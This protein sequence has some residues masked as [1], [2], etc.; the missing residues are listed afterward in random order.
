MGCDIHTRVEYLSVNKKW[1]CGDLFRL[2]PYYSADDPDECDPFSVMEVCGDRDY[3]LFATLANVRNY[4]DTA[5]IAEPRGIPADACARTYRDYMSWGED[6]HSAS[7]FTLKELIDWNRKAPPLKQSGMVSPEDAARLDA[8]QGTPKTWCQWTSD[9]TWVKREWEDDY[10]PLDRLIEELI[11][12][13]KELYLLYGNEDDIY[14]KSDRL[15][16]IFWF[17]N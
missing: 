11:I 12:R 13:G 15:R 17:D 4:G 3:D 6:A 7:Y 2:N 14:Q 1:L 8:G 10:K 9:E 16:F 5:Y